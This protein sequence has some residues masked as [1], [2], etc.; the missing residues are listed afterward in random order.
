MSVFKTDVNNAKLNIIMMLDSSGSMTGARIGQLN[1]GVRECLDLIK[2]M[3]GLEEVNVEI[4]IMQFDGTYAWVLGNDEK[5]L[6]PEEAVSEFRDIAA[7][8][9]ITCTHD[10]ISQVG[11]CLKTIYAEGGN[12][13]MPII[14]LVTDGLSTYPDKT[15]EA[16]TNLKKLLHGHTH[17]DEERTI[18]VSIGVED[19]NRDELVRF[20]SCRN[21][22]H[23][24]GTEETDVPNV[25]EVDQVENLRDVLRNITMASISNSL[26]A[27]SGGSGSI[28][29]YEDDTT[30][31][32]ASSDDFD[33]GIWEDL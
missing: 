33:D 2:E 5:G 25:F 11:E 9:N 16:C 32:S 17:K 30:D 19:A 20:A 26:S 18:R 6:T 21:I 29:E 3:D 14:I 4:R 12:N 10:A 27:G 31:I 28:I 15:A 1:L 7:N 8:R 24:D 23:S 22:V 13:Y